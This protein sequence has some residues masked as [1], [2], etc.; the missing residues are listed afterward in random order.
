MLIIFNGIPAGISDG[1]KGYVLKLAVRSLIFPLKRGN[2]QVQIV[3]FFYS[4][5]KDPDIRFENV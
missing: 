2:Y 3:V 4:L 5:L 1:L